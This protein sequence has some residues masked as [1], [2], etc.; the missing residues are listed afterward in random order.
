MA[1]LTPDM[2]T[3]GIK[4]IKPL[5]DFGK[6]LAEPE[7]IPSRDNPNRM[8]TRKKPMT[9]SQIR[10]FFGAIK[11]IQADFNNLKGEIILLEPKLAYAVGRDKNETKIDIF[12]KELSPLIKSINE[13]EMKFKNFVSIVEA[14]VAYHKVYG[15][16]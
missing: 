16:E 12:Y 14:I 5:E 8:I 2:L 13:D 4:N 3:N 9:T 1:T 6:N 10:R 7:R 11:R 15:G